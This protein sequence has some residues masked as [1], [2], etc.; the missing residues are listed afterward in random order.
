[1]S[2]IPKRF[3]TP[4]SARNALGELR[5]VAERMCRLYR[6]MQ[7]RRP[8]RITPE[9]RVEPEYFGL[10]KQ[11]QEGLD[12]VRASGAQVKDLREGMLDFPARREGRLVLLCWKVGE[13]S[14]RFWHETGTGYA[15]RRPVDEDGPWEEA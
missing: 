15:A 12:E 10:L 8:K 3:F 4:R 11:L 6:A 9:Q 14:L 5:P 13:A 7:S 2:R 1:M